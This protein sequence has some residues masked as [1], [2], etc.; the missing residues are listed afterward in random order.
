MLTKWILIS[1][2]L[3]ISY[4][5]TFRT[6]LKQK[7]VPKYKKILVYLVIYIICIVGISVVTNDEL[8]AYI[9]IFLGL[10]PVT[11]AEYFFI[12]LKSQPT[13]VEPM[14][15]ETILSDAKKWVRL[16]LT[17]III[18]IMIIN[19][20]EDKNLSLVFSIVAVLLIAIN[21]YLGVKKR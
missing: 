9:T 8:I 11:V 7:N 6:L 19:W 20:P 2:F 13:V 21:Y 15:R 1:V 3:V 5:R 17:F 16:I 12:K 18:S 14:T 10:I 4:F